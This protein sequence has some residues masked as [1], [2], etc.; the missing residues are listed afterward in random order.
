[1]L[2]VAQNES[3]FLGRIPLLKDVSTARQRNATQKQALAEAQR[4]RE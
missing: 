4:K 1:M 3:L 2:K